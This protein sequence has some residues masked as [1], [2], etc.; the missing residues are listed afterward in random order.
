MRIPCCHTVPLYRWS[1]EHYATCVHCIEPTSPGGDSS[2]LRE[3]LEVTLRFSLFITIAL[4]LYAADFH[5]YFLW[6][7]EVLNSIATP[8]WRHPVFIFFFKEK[9]SDYSSYFKLLSEMQRGLQLLMR[10]FKSLWLTLPT[11][12]RRKEEH[13]WD[14]KTVLKDYHTRG[15]NLHENNQLQVVDFNEGLSWIEGRIRSYTSTLKARP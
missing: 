3:L 7:P 9:V 2:V 5:V 1:M 13:C 14:S 6:I 11:W 15:E 4:R 12:E 10:K 8:R